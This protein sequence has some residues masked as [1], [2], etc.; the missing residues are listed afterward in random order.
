MYLRSL[1]GEKGDGGL[2]G[3]ERQAPFIGP[4]LDPGG[5]ASEG[6]CCISVVTGGDGVGEIICI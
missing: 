5:L 1:R 6:R 3:G 4:L 2:G